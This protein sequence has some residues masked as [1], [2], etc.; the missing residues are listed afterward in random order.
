MMDGG[1]QLRGTWGL[2]PPQTSS[3][4]KIDN[5]PGATAGQEGGSLVLGFLSQYLVFPA[6]LPDPSQSS[7]QTETPGACL[8][9][10]GG[11]LPSLSCCVE[12]ER[13]NPGGSPLMSGEKKRDS[14]KSFRTGL[15]CEGKESFMPLSGNRATQ[16]LASARVVLA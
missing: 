15:R 4:A 13:D 8:P 1:A 5:P 2:P 16:K 11:G 9:A 10:Q 3:K 14:R 12:E 6:L 7:P